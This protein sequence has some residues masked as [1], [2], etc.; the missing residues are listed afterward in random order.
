TRPSGVVEGV[1]S[2]ATAGGSLGPRSEPLWPRPDPRATDCPF[3]ELELPND[4]SRQRACQRERL[5]RNIDGALDLASRSAAASNM[6]AFQ[7]RALDLIT[8]ETTR[9][10]LRID[11]EDPRLRDRY[12]RNVFGQRCLLAPRLIEGGVPLV[13]LYSV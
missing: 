12:G 10:A 5:L 11:R 3:R 8:S 7:T 9:G 1:P 2:P 13:D 4:F 6:T